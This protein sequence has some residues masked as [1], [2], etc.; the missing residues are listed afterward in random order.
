[1]RVQIRGWTGGLRTPAD[2]FASDWVIRPHF[3][4][5]QGLLLDK[6]GLEQRLQDGPWG[7]WKHGRT[8]APTVKDV[9]INL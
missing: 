9:I 6:R 5:W 4:R 1:M 8:I 2:Q 3:W 7:V